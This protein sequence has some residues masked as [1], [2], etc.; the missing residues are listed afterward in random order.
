LP[1]IDCSMANSASMRRATSMAIGESGISFFPAALRRAFS[2]IS[3]MTKNGRRACTQ[4]AA[5]RI[6]PGL[7]SA[8]YSLL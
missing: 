4:H 5:S 3:A 1:L 8:R 6:G 7:R 2:S